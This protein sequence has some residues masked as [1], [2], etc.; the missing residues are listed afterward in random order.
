MDDSRFA[1]Q[2]APANTAPSGAGAPPAGEGA[3][4][5]LVG[6]VDGPMLAPIVPPS[7]DDRFAPGAPT[8]TPAGGDG[9]LRPTGTMP[10]SPPPREAAPEQAFTFPETNLVNP[11][12]V[13]A[14][15]G[16][17]APQLRAHRLTIPALICAMCVPIPLVPLIGAIV[18]GYVLARMRHGRYTAYGVAV[19]ALGLGV[20][21]SLGQLFIALVSLPLFGL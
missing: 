8:I 9:Y 16:Y 14:H 7:G 21:F 10:A 13:F 5:R 15:P 17:Q 3:P 18:A 12:E 19:T 1:P 11:A 2:P 4:V 6:D 20:V